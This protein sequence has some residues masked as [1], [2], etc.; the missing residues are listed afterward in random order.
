MATSSVVMSARSVANVLAQ[1]LRFAI[2]Q[3]PLF[4]C[5][6]LVAAALASAANVLT[7]RL[8]D[9]N[10]AEASGRLRSLSYVV[11]DHADRSLLAVRQSVAKV[12]RALE[13]QRPATVADMEKLADTPEIHAMLE[14]VV[15]DNPFLESVFV[16]GADGRTDSGSRPGMI[17]P[18]MLAD[19]DYM[20]QLHDAGARE[21]YMSAPFQSYRFHTW[22]LNYSMRVSAP[23]GAFLG[24]VAG[25]VKLS[26]FT[27]LFD[28]VDFSAGGSISLFSADGRLLTWAPQSEMPLG[29]SLE[30]SPL[31]NEFMAPRHE[32]VTR[33][34]SRADGVERLLAIANVPDFPISV[35]VA[36]AMPA[37]IAKGSRQA[38]EIDMVGSLASAAVLIG[39]ALLALGQD[40]IAEY[41]RRR[42]V[43]A[44]SAEH[45]EM[46]ANAIENIGQGLAMFDR[47]GDLMLYNARYAEMQG[48]KNGATA[49]DPARRGAVGLALPA[50]GEP[51]EP[52]TTYRRL[53]DGR[54]IA[55]R[56]RAL[57]GGGW[58]STQE[59]V[60]DKRAAEEKIRLMA[61]RDA[62][63][64]L[65]NRA[66][67]MEMLGQRLLGIPRGGDKAAVLCVDL[68]GFKGVNATFGLSVGDALIRLVGERMS[69]IMREGD[70]AARFSADEFAVLQRVSHVSRDPALLAQR[71][72]DAVG[73]PYQIGG[74]SIEIGVSIGIAAAP[75]DG[76]EAEALVRNAE[77][78]LRH[79]KRESGS[80]YRFF[81]AA[82]DDELRARRA[83]ELDLEA[84]VAAKAF[85][86][87]LQPV[88]SV[89][90]RA[91]NSFEAL[92]RWRHPERGMVSPAEFI[93]L[94]EETGLIV[95]IGEWVLAEA[96]RIAARLPPPLRIGVNV[97][98]AQFHAPGLLETFQSALAAAGIEGSRL[99]VEITEG[100]M[101]DDADAAMQTLHAMRERGAAVAMD[102]FGS[103][104]SSLS[105]LHKFPFD[106]VK[107]D[108]SFV[109]GLGT[110]PSAETIVRA[111]I[112]L[113]DALRIGSVAEGIE[114]EAQMKFLADA[115]CLE[116]QGYLISR[117]MPFADARKFLGLPDSEPE[118]APVAN[119]TTATPGPTRIAQPRH[120][121]GA[122]SRPKPP[123]FPGA[124]RAM[125]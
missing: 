117:P 31:L 116:A 74:D 17:P 65:Y 63:T 44:L 95:P 87:Y 81:T 93:P 34:R 48:V 56:K 40:A 3:A 70:E 58:I 86:L 107:I 84:A 125:R 68:D 42:A 96:C 88:V 91:V 59:D 113:A 104:Y 114:T 108:K 36:T 60:T 32:G 80:V 71:L 6:L 43:D 47:D 101:I 85:E 76:E 67:F 54:I 62:L 92:I 24:A 23:D 105:N 1:G 53:R 33:V 97:S 10:F 66:E 82:M 122:G 98:P 102:D 115:G 5:A 110:D 121:L 75:A 52:E 20:G 4:V 28:K 109:G 78:A 25:I 73:R 37:V 14:D 18:E 55:Q 29:D 38:H 8:Y 103:G 11:S 9:E 7:N 89:K 77:I 13:T 19:G 50:P 45:G 41:R 120:V 39:A 99:I 123:T 51:A 112:A 16:V 72:L 27:S 79:A 30:D 15:A 69:S 57:P 26:P 2:R 111:A 12:A 35:V 49:E 118:T 94:A 83:L 119:R 106:K 90:D 22:M 100:V 46:L 124:R 64:G 21:A 61:T